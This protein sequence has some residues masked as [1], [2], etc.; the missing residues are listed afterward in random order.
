MINIIVLQVK[1]DRRQFIKIFIK[2]IQAERKSFFES[3]LKSS[4]D[5]NKR[6]NH[7]FLNILSEYEKC[8][9]NHKR[10]EV[11]SNQKETNKF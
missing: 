11:Y 2:I 3:D 1:F 10:A 8:S 4:R 5:R 7:D 9:E 6:I